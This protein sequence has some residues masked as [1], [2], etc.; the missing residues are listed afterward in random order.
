MGG[1][2]VKPSLRLAGGETIAVQ[3]P[4]AEEPLSA[5]APEL[6]PLNVVYEDRD[7]LVI[8]KPAGL[9]VHPAVGHETGT[10]VNALLARYPYLEGSDPEGRPGIVHRLDKDTSGLLVVGKSQRAVEGLKAQFKAQTVR[11]SYLALVVGHLP[12]AQ[13][14]IDAPVGRHPRWRQRF[15]VRSDGRPA[16]TR[17]TVLE[18]W[19]GYSLVEARPE[20][21]R[22]HQIRVHFA[23]IGHPVAGDPVYG[24]R[25]DR[26]GVGRQ[27]LHASSL[28][29]R[30]PV[31]GQPLEFTSPL[32][33]DLQRAL[34]RLRE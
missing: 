34:D 27:Y 10:L 22:T 24:P 30:H 11:K 17:F 14:L 13:G 15:T 28:G 3:L 19:P 7:V 1:E 9:A 33:N 18:T 8:D 12:V 29:F 26:L 21:G 31:T 20:T 4:P 16:R 2:P 6:I 25:K 5:P 32:P 23:Y